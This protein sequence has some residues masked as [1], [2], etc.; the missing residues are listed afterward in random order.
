MKDDIDRYYPELAE[1][2]YEITSDETPIYNCIA[3]AMGDTTQWWECGRDGPIDEP[4]FY[5]PEGAEHGFGLQ[6]LINAYETM[7]FE[8][9]Q[10]GGPVPEEGYEKVALYAENGEWRHAA[11]QLVD[12][13]WSSK[14]GELEDVCHES[15]ADVCG[16]FNGELTC[17]MRRVVRR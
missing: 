14:L 3:W 15:P 1:A 4:G 9:C 13:R 7:G 11:R 10:E 2:G 16:E 5:W 17:F 12:G 8:L 6:A